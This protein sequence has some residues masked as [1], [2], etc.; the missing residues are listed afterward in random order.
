MLLDNHMNKYNS[1][2]YFIIWLLNLIYWL[3]KSTILIIVKLIT[4]VILFL[5]LLLNINFI[6]L[7]TLDFRTLFYLD[8]I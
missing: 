5:T 1:I 3:N 7:G 6:L 4:K 2:N 8:L